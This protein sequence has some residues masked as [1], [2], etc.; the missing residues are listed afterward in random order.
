LDSG[1]IVGLVAGDVDEPT[2]CAEGLAVVARV[3][4]G[5]LLWQ[6]LWRARRRAVCIW[7]R[8]DEDE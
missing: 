6:R 5:C 2:T 1:N 3:R 7:Q 4:M 8:N